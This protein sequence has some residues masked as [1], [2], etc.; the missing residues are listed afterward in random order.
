MQ[1]FGE[2]GFFQIIIYKLC[3]VVMLYSLIH[4]RQKAN[5]NTDFI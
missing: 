4:G 5:D 2:L 1:I 3:I